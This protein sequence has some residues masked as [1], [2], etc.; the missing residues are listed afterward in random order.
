MIVA[1]FPGRDDEAAQDDVDL[2]LDGLVGGRWGALAASMKGTSLRSPS[3][4]FALLR[5]QDWKYRKTRRSEPFFN[6]I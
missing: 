5:G 6:F 1:K 2:G 4:M 3:A